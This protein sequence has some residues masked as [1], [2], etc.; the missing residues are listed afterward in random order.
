[1]C[2][3]R[4]ISPTEVQVSLELNGHTFERQ[5]FTDAESATQFAIDK[6]H[7]YGGR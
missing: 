2:H 1:M 5:T 6:M 3:C 7:A 4:L